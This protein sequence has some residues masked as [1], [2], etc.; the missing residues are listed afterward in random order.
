MNNKTVTEKLA[1]AGSSYDGRR[2]HAL[3]GHY[4]TDINARTTRLQWSSIQ[5]WL[6]FQ[7]IPQISTEPKNHTFRSGL[8]QPEPLLEEIPKS[9]ARKKTKQPLTEVSRYTPNENS[10]Y[11]PPLSPLQRV[12][13]DAGDSPPWVIGERKGGKPILSFQKTRSR[14]DLEQDSSI[15]SEHFAG[16]NLK[17]KKE[18][19]FKG[20]CFWYHHLKWWRNISRI[21]YR[22]LLW[23]I[24]RHFQFSIHNVKIDW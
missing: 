9:Q 6:E 16:R 18:K 7:N 19:K 5:N 3:N 24:V 10:V 8:P 17:V 4:I 12:T 2:D 13:N 1:Q 22:K 23:K 20:L 11:H 15:Q 14:P 21:N